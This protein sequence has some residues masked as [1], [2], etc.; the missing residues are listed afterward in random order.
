MQI[1]WFRCGRHAIYKGHIWNWH[2]HTHTPHMTTR[3]ICI[4]YGWC[5]TH[6]IILKLVALMIRHARNMF[7]WKDHPLKGNLL[8]SRLAHVH[9]CTWPIW[10]FTFQ[11]HPNLFVQFSSSSSPSNIFLFNLI[12]HLSM[13]Y[14]FNHTEFEPWLRMQCAHDIFWLDGSSFEM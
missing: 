12:L 5:F 13:V 9:Y 14:L 11:P 8:H 10:F 3:W 6:L 7:G 4:L 1:K 2:I